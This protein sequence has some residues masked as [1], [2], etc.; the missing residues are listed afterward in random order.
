M[1]WPGVR[2]PIRDRSE[3]LVCPTNPGRWPT[4]AGHLHSQLRLRTP[5]A[6]SLIARSCAPFA[7]PAAIRCGLGTF[8]AAVDQGVKAVTYTAA[9]RDLAREESTDAEGELCPLRLEPTANPRA[10]STLGAFPE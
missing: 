10:R 9:E 4:L 2:A 6:L 1:D 7:V 8:T 5:V 3:T